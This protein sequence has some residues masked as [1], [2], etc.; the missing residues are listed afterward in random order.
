MS[1]IRRQQKGH[2]PKFPGDM[3]PMSDNLK[4]KSPNTKGTADLNKMSDNLKKKSPKTKG[5][6]K[7]CI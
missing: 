2:R 4:P 1:V 3:N 6:K 5:A 7:G